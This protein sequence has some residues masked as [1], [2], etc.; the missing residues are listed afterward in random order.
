MIYHP[1]SNAM[2]D[3]LAQGHIDQFFAV[4]MDAPTGVVRAHT[5]LGELVINGEVYIGLGNLGT[6]SAAK[7]DGG[8]SPQDINLSLSLLDPSL[9]AMALNEQVVNSPVEIMMGVF[10]SD[11]T[12]AAVDI[13]FA[14]SVTAVSAVMGDENQVT[15]T[16]SSE[17]Y[18][19]DKIP[20]NRYT[21]ESH[22]QRYLGDRFFR[23]VGQMAE[24]TVYWGSKS[25]APGFIYK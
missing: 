12:I 22:Q 14:G 6:I 9:M 3:A 25:D 8:T 11:G 7:Q 16:C 1:Y 13:L 23:Y 10:Y 5:G 18:E 21:D 19:W 2:I 4:R 24:R 20:S 17:L 15:Y